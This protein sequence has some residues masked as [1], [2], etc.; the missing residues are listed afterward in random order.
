MS[1][2]VE[3]WEVLL[4]KEVERLQE[5]TRTNGGNRHTA[6]IDSQIA[7][8]LNKLYF[9]SIEIKW[10]HTRLTQMLMEREEI[11]KLKN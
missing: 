7:K 10:K 3:S 11:Y 1:A 4:S 9:D 2:S 6:K 8:A 5:I